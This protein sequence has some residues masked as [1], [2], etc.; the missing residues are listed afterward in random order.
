MLDKKTV[1]KGKIN[2]VIENNGKLLGIEGYHRSLA[3]CSRVFSVRHFE[4]REEPGDEVVLV[5]SR[6]QESRIRK[7]TQLP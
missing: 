4:Y 2:S 7:V 5:R 1:N 3:A 6:F